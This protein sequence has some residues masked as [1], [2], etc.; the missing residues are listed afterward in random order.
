MVAEYEGG[1]KGVVVEVKIWVPMRVLH[2]GNLD[3]FGGEQKLRKKNSPLICREIMRQSLTL[4][5]HLEPI[6][7]SQLQVAASANYHGIQWILG[8]A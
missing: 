8:F 4:T 7:L 1:H 6:L 5:F 3:F 2:V